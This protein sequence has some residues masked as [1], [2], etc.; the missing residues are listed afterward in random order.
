M[1]RHVAPSISSP[2]EEIHHLIPVVRRILREE[3]PT[4]SERQRHTVT[5]FAVVSRIPTL[6]ARDFADQCVRN[7]VGGR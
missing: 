4:L 6:A 7:G 3:Y 5:C 1:M 2:M